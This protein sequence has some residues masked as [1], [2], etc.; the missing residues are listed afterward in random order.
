MHWLPPTRLHVLHCCFKPGQ[1]PAA[2]HAPLCTGCQ[3]AVHEFRQR[4]GIRSPLNI[5]PVPEQVRPAGAACG[6]PVAVVY[7]T[8]CDVPRDACCWK[9]LRMGGMCATPR[10][11]G[12]LGC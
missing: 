8:A 9:L 1:L 4:R 3:R 11:Q 2:L 7:R 5:Q 6:A 12:T 10:A